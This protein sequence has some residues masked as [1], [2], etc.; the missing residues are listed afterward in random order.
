M[1]YISFQSST[2]L[3]ETVALIE[4]KE[5]TTCT[6]LHRDTAEGKDSEK[7]R[8][9]MKIFQSPQDNIHPKILLIEG[10][11]G[12]GKTVLCKEIAFRWA[13]GE[14]LTSCKLLLLL[15]LRDPNV[16]KISSV[17]ELAEHFTE[18]NDEANSL[19]SYLDNKGSVTII[20]DGFD[21]IN[22]KLRKS[23]FITKLIKRQCL[24]KATIVAT[25]RPFAYMK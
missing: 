16:Q 15:F 10:H 5:T 24:P 4:S 7:L 8:D 2:K 18:S 1:S 25:S 20:I 14:V 9:L 17:Q 3:Y 19:Y 22:G 13:K 21:E 11:P 6:T 23:S 12:I